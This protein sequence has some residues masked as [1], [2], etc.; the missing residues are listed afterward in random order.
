MRLSDA[1]QRAQEVKDA[2]DGD[3]IPGDPDHGHFQRVQEPVTL[4]PVH[5]P[6]IP[7]TVQPP[8]VL[9]VNNLPPISVGPDNLARFNNGARVPARRVIPPKPL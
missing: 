3:T 7:V 4:P 2:A 5:T 6:S 8:F 1:I 9:P